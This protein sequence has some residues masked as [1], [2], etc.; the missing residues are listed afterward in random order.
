MCEERRGHEHAFLKIY[1]PNQVPKSMFTVIDEQMP[2]ARAD[3]EQ[4]VN[5]QQQFP[6]FFRNMVGQMMSGIHKGFNEH[7]GGREG[8]CGG[9][10]RKWGPHGGS[11][12]QDGQWKNKKA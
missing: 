10:G 6:T 4:Q 11:R 5:E 8:H 3:I 7:K 12:G 2:N 9:R 1:N